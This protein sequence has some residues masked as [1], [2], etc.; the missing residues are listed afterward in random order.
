[1]ERKPIA[2]DPMNIQPEVLHCVCFIYAT[3]KGVRKP[4]GT[5][6]FMTIP[7]G[8]SGQ[9]TFILATALLPAAIVG[10]HPGP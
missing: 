9:E 4:V 7:I 6:F 8:E 5:A 3:I 2:W 1:V 10:V